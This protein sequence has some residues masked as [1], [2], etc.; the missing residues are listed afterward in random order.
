M[1]IIN[2]KAT[3]NY[4]L[5]E[6]FEAGISLT[7]AEVKSIKKGKIDLSAAYGKI[8]GD[9][10]YL[11]NA[12]IPFEGAIDN[13][14]T[15]SRKLLLHKNEIVAINAKIKAKKLTLVPTKVYTRGPFIKLEIALAKSKK[16]FEKKE[17]LKKKDIEREMEK[18]LKDSVKV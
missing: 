4:K 9:E 2:R 1:K 17:L 8:L 10:A 3:F 15:R 13:K 16:R 18:Q 11:V 5:L 6:K 7:G 12:N 14:S